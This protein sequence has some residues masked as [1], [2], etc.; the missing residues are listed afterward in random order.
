MMIILATQVT[1][2]AALACSPQPVEIEEPA[3][4]EVTTNLVAPMFFKADK[5]V[6]AV[7]RGGHDFLARLTVGTAE[8]GKI[9]IEHR[10]GEL[11]AKQYFELFPVQ[12]VFERGGRA[13]APS[14]ISIARKALTSGGT[15]KFTPKV[16]NPASK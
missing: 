5:L 15:C 7:D 1:V 2:L 10:P 9:K 16:R 4:A 14:Q 13:L 12:L 11:D 8:G 6:S 3:G